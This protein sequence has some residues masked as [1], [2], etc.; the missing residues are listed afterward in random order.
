VAK[1]VIHTVGPIYSGT[2]SDRTHLKNSYYNSLKI[3]LKNKIKSIAFPSISTGIFGYPVA[4]AS[5]IALSTI[6]GFLEEH[7]EVEIVKMV[8]FSDSDY[9]VYKDTLENVL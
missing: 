8:L 1:Y 7:P 6:I 2:E 3:A 9:Q 5:E 4:E